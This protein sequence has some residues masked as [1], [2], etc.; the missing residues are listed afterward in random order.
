[1]NQPNA[2]DS[3]APEPQPTQMTHYEIEATALYLSGLSMAAFNTLSDEIRY[4][5][6]FAAKKHLTQLATARQQL[7]E[8]VRELEKWKEEDPRMLREQ[9]RVA[10]V[11]FQSLHER[12]V[13]IT[14]DRDRLASELASAHA[15]IAVM[16]EELKH[17][18]SGIDYISWGKIKAHCPTDLAKQLTKFNVAADNAIANLPTAAKTFLEQKEATEKELAAAKSERARLKEQMRVARGAFEIII[19]PNPLS[20]DRGKSDYMRN[21]AKEALAK[22]S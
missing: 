21:I 14:S 15:Q 16:V 8:R 2:N 19:A 9:I 5:Y 1:M 10:D 12:L 3:P 11:A 22:L 17:F 13:V 7:N 20:L 6:R 4:N 18:C